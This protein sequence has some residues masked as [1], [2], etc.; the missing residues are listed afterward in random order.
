MSQNANGKYKMNKLAK[1]NTYTTLVKDI[2]ELYHRTRKTLV[3]SY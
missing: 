1:T 3:E 2:A